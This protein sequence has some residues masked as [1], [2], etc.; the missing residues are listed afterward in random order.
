MVVGQYSQSSSTQSGSKHP[1]V[2]LLKGTTLKSHVDSMV[3][4]QLKEKLAKLRVN[5]KKKEFSVRE[6]DSSS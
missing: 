4:K 2:K 3:Q 5:A 1:K 6:I